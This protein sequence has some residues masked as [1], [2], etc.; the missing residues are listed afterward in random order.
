MFATIAYGAM[1]PI[2]DD[3]FDNG[4]ISDYEWA[5]EPTADL[6]HDITHVTA[7][8]GRVVSLFEDCLNPSAPIEWITYPSMNEVGTK[9]DTG[10]GETHTD[11]LAQFM[12]NWAS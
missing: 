4:V 3:L 5:T 10:L 7:H 6:P 12:T 9:Y 11:D 2:L 8:D 1:R